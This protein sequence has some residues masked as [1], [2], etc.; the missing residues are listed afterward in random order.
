MIVSHRHRFVFLKT[1]KTAGTSIEIFLSRFLGPDDI[2]TPIKPVDEALR[3]P[4]GAR[5]YLRD[6]G[7]FGWKALAGRLPGPVGR[8]ARRPDHAIDFYNHI[9]AER[10]RALLGDE[11]WSGYFKFAFERNPWD[12]QVSY[13]HWATRG[14]ARPPSFREFTLVQGRRVRGWPIYAIGDRPAV[15]LVGRYET[16]EADLARVLDRLGIDAPVELP[17]AKAGLRPGRDW[18]DYYDTETRALI[19]RVN[20][21]EIALMG[22][23]F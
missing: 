1:G 16:L 17:R 10:A 22:Y 18:R 4:N 14:E 19:G 3:A 11:V 12:K 9:R 7:L 21:R 13:Y 20:K 8:F 15:D 6:T 23:E 5:N 2:A